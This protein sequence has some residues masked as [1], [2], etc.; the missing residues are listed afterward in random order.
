MLSYGNA[1]FGY[2][3][4]GSLK[5]KAENGDTTRY[6][7]DLLGNL[8]SVQLPNGTYIQYLIDGQNR[9][10]AKIVNGRIKKRWLYQNQLNI[11]AE[12]DSVGNLVS[13]FIYGTKGHVP[14]Y[15]LKN[16]I[17]YRFVTDHL[18]SVRFLVDVASGAVV[19]Y[20]SYDEFGNILSDTYPGFQPFGYAGGLYDGHTGL[21]RFGARDY[22]AFIGRWYKKEPIGFGLS[23]INSFRYINSDPINYLDIDGL[24]IID[25]RYL[26]KNQ[27]RDFKMAT[28][29]IDNLL[30]DPQFINEPS[31]KRYA[32]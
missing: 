31:P 7:Y 22:D 8:R 2:T 9:R 13:R 14:D 5:W 27:L 10:V 20:I 23:S 16:G 26:T 24:A 6:D 29:I 30:N 19:Q 3:A 18:G 32:S 15:M 28:D 4:T 12:L 1:T 21:M 11:V 25:E 17:T